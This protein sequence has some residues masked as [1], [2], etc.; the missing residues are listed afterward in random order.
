MRAS[1]LPPAPDKWIAGH[2]PGE[3]SRVG[4][5]FSDGQK[6]PSMLPQAEPSCTLFEAAHLLNRACFGGSPSEIETFHALGREKTVDSLLAPTE[7]LDAFPLPAWCSDEVALADMRA[8]VEMRKTIQQAVRNQSPEEAEKAKRETNKEFQKENRMRALEAQ[9]W[10]FRR[11]LK[12]GAP[13]REKMTLFW[14]DHF[15][16]SVQKVK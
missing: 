2:E 14:H 16:T 9:G 11:M 12:T 4:G 8:R 1:H 6:F 13:L 10:R 3:T 5:S 7:Q 15:A